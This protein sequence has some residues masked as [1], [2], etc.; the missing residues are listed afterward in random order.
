[1]LF[2]LRRKSLNAKIRRIIGKS[3][4]VDNDRVLYGCDY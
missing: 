1:M 2:I 4:V 3:I